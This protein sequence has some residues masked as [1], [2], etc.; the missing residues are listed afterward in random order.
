MLDQ[1]M[2]DLYTDYLITSTS[3]TTATGLSELLDHAYSHDQI[4]RFLGQEQYHQKQYWRQIKSTV[5][6]I[7]HED[8]V[9]IVDDT[10]EE[11]PYTDENDIVCWH[12]DHTTNRHVKGM[13]LLNFVYHRQFDD[14]RD[15]SC[16]LSY[17]IIAKTETYVDAKTG[18]TKR[19]SPITKNALMRGRLKI[20]TFTNGISYRYVLWDSWF[21]SADNLKFVKHTLQK[22]VIGAVKSNRTVALSA[23]DKQHGQFV[24]VSDLD[25][26]PGTTREV[27][28]RDVDF[29]VLLTTQVFINKDGSSGVLY[30]IST[31][32]TLSYTEITTLYQRRWNVETFHKSLKQNASLAKSPT[33]VE[34]TQRNHIFAAMLAFLKLERLKLKTTL[35]HFALKHRL[36]MK[37]LKSSFAELQ[38]IKEHG[39]LPNHA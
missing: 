13:N 7:E 26:D 34:R 8:G 12:F 16:P 20:L 15:F 27:Y 17:E 6:R 36:Y 19:K 5:R 22:D 14:D 28:L 31:D 4:T 3:A 33:K 25:S 32:T 11:K 35:N 9:I 23:E 37:A 24:A 2:L 38:H 18:K 10:I 1:H 21:S 29:P 39:L 30:L